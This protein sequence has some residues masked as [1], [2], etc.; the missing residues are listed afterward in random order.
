MITAET[1]KNDTS[2][3]L[4]TSTDV[5]K[6]VFTLVE[7]SFYSIISFNSKHAGISHTSS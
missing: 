4:L 1:L 3:Q 7:I 6:S 5:E 2:V